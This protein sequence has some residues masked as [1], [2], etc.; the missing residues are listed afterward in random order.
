MSRGNRVNV[1]MA[2]S[3]V[4]GSSDKIT[5]KSNVCWDFVQINEGIKSAKIV[6]DGTRVKWCD[7]YESLKV[8]IEFVF[9]PTGKTESIRRQFKEF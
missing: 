3:H 9:L 7:N 5:K 1:K 2:Y 4:L 8:F 6:Y